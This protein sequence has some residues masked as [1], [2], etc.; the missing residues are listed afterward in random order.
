M[1]FSDTVWC[2]SESPYSALLCW[3][4]VLL[5]VDRVGC[6]SVSSAPLC[7]LL[8][9]GSLLTDPAAH[10]TCK[11]LKD[12]SLYIIL[13]ESNRWRPGKQALGSQRGKKQEYR[14]DDF[15][16]D[17]NDAKL[18]FRRSKAHEQEGKT[19]LSGML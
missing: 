9:P 5:S 4:Q 15:L 3:S 14:Q 12:K 16:W 11:S 17:N 18:V 8:P 10:D 7:C 19:K 13:H 1:S 6:R 2:Y